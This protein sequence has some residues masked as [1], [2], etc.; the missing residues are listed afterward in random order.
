MGV[1]KPEM[2]LMEA[3][4]R[5]IQFLYID[6][7]TT[8]TLDYNWRKCWNNANARMC[9]KGAVIWSHLNTVTQIQWICTLVLRKSS[10]SPGKL[11]SMRESILYLYGYSQKSKIIQQSFNHPTRWQSHTRIND[12]NSRDYVYN[13]VFH[14]HANLYTVWSRRN[15]I[16]D[17]L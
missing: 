14:G 10:R 8:H 12:Y 3:N 5:D 1:T 6:Q 15:V 11:F 13:C 7:I 4:T 16:L 17:T 9:L 2:G